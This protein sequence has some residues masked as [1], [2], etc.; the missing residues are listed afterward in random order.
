MLI[1]G[2]TGSSDDWRD[3]LPALG[4]LGPTFAPDLRGHGDSTNLGEEGAYT[5]DE[6]VEDLAATLDALEIAK[7]DLLG[8][9]MG[10]MLTLR[11]ALRYPKRLHSLILMDTADVPLQLAPPDQFD[12]LVGIVSAGGTEALLGVTKGRANQKAP[13]QKAYEERVGVDAAWARIEA[14]VRAMDP[15]AFIGFARELSGQTPVRD[16]IHA[17]ECPTLV[18]VGEED[19]AFIAP[20]EAMA[21]QIPN[22]RKLVI[23]DAAHSPQLE[24]P[25]AWLEA[26]RGHLEAARR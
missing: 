16:L 6:L 5:L 18:L 11:F 26:I 8:H 24:N 14:K 25:T 19:A 13:A 10:G 15:Q 17:I 23:P 4:A 22:A 7:C 21:K 1:H 9:S 12:K 3:H 20:T 2:F